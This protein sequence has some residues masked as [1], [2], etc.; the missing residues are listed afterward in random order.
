MKIEAI[1]RRLETASQLLNQR[2]AS[3]EAAPEDF[4]ARL[5]VASLESHVRDLQTQLREAKRARSVEVVQIRLSGKRAD[6]GRLPLPIL[7]AISD[8]FTA[9]ISAA[10]QKIKNGRVVQ[11][12]SAAM[13]DFVD[14]RL[15]DVTS[16]STRLFITGETAPDLFGNSLLED[17]LEYAFALL[18]AEND[19]IL[20]ARVSEIGVRSAKAWR[21]LLDTVANAGLEMD[22]EWETP[23]HAVRRWS[24][25]PESTTRLREALGA[26]SVVETEHFTARATVVALSLRGRFELNASGRILSGTFA[27]DLT[28][29]VMGIGLGDQVVA[30]LEKSVLQNAVTGTR[31]V[32]YTLLGIEPVGQTN[33]DA[34][35]QQVKRLTGS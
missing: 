22:L 26:F 34:G 11:R 23:A 8:S 17:S 27:L 25:T 9:A 6:D 2:R 30:V 20:S 35:S 5:T 12:I 33:L 24:G 19:D 28:S 1:E 14:L 7:S 16:G 15:A 13:I 29:R 4:A 18:N 31:K 32:G 3:C 10:S 21:D